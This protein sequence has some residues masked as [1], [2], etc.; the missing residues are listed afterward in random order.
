MTCLRGKGMIL[1]LIVMS[2]ILMPTLWAEA[3][4]VKLS[5][6]EIRCGNHLSNYIKLGEFMYKERYKNNRIV[7]TCIKLFKDSN[8]ELY[9][10]PVKKTDSQNNKMLFE[11]TFNKSVGE[12]YNLL[13]YHVCNDDQKLKNKILF[14]SSSEK[15]FIILPKKLLANQCTYFWTEISS[16]NVNSIKL[17][18]ASGNEKTLKVRKTFQ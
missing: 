5:I 7:D 2:S 3:Y 12:K 8:S 1:G 6:T 4:G 14:Q 13:K 16:E 18:W 17:S 9:L 15:S 11:L 10:K